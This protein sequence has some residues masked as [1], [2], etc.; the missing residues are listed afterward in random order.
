MLCN[1][2]FSAILKFLYLYDNPRV[3]ILVFIFY[4]CCLCWLFVIKP[5]RINPDQFY[6]ISTFLFPI[7]IIGFF[8]LLCPLKLPFNGTNL[9][10]FCQMSDAFFLEELC[11]GVLTKVQKFRI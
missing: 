8:F 9:N 1:P 7:I 10:V 11:H 4:Q 6:S 2:T 3:L 5:Y